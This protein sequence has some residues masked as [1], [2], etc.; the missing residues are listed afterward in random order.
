MFVFK[1]RSMVRKVVRIG[2]RVV[3]YFQG[4]F[5]NYISFQW[6]QLGLGFVVVFRGFWYRQFDIVL[7][8]GLGYVV[9]GDQVG[10]GSLESGGRGAIRSGREEQQ[11]LIIGGNVGVG[12]E[13]V[14]FTFIRFGSVRFGS[15]VFLFSVV[16]YLRF[17]FFF[18]KTSLK[19]WREGRRARRE[20]WRIIDQQGVWF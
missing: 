18:R 17:V 7:I 19:V 20:D 10:W 12:G 5:F 6:E 4:F 8:W 14:R 13:L 16:E 2:L 11:L 9:F 1:L 3:E 15:Q